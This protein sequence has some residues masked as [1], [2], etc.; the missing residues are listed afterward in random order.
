MARK[1]TKR[2]TK[3]VRPDFLWTKAVRGFKLECARRRTIRRMAARGRFFERMKKEGASMD[4]EIIEPR[5]LLDSDG[6]I[7]KEGWARQ[8]YWRYDQS[9]IKAPWWRI[10]EWDY[11]AIL[12]HDGKYGVTMTI[13]DLGYIGLDALCFLDFERGFSSSADTL[14]AFPRHRTGLS[15]NSDT[16]AVSFRDAKLAV[17]Y[18]YTPGRRLL[19]F[20]APG[21]RNAQGEQGLKGSVVLS[22]PESLESLNIA[23]SWAENRRAF[24]YNRKIN[25]M[26]AEGSFTI[27][28]TKYDFDPKRDFGALD[29]GRGR[30]TYKNRWYW[31]SA[32]GYVGGHAFGWNIG[33]GFTDRTPASENV[34][35]YDGKA[36]KLDEVTFHIDTSD[37]SRPWRFTSSDG[38]FEMDFEPVVDRS[39]NTNLGII[40]SDQHQV[41][42]YFTG[43]AILDDGKKLELNRFLGFA[44]DVLNWY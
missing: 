6:R 38:R 24:Y 12:S 16:G 23:T 44:E 28:S 11:Y 31:G 14:V 9:K 17:R 22:Q 41:F 18:E 20:E 30:W 15:P 33:Y 29:W 40:K 39:S 26:P 5:E 32:S 35:F 25:C 36:H 8:P 3:M 27:G 42:G 21:V 13:S 4:I 19:E 34:L 10:K 37:Y 1:E 7:T 2:Q 43:S